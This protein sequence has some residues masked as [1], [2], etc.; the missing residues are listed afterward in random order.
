MKSYNGL[1]YPAMADA[2]GHMNV[3]H[4]VAAFDQA[5]WQAVAA[6]GYDTG[7][8]RSR[9]QGWA[10]V[11]HETH[12][13]QELEVG[14]L[15]EVHTDVEAVGTSSLTLR[16][17]M[18]NRQGDT[19]ATMKMKTVYF[20]LNARKSIPLPDDLRNSAQAHLLSGGEPA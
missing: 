10:D 16:H 18:K 1:V 15:F 9:G 19:V 13:M 3:Q 14:A 12:F 7:W 20:D 4:Y 8:Q 17:T 5:M 11:L 6:L 2:M